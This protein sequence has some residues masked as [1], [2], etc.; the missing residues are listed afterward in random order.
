MNT[1]TPPSPLT[2]R[3]QRYRSLLMCAPEPVFMMDREGHFL[4]VND[5]TVRML[6]Y[7][8]E[9]LLKLNFRDI[10]VRDR[11]PATEAAFA[12]QMSSQQATP[13][14]KIAVLVKGGRRLELVV[15]GGP[16]VVN[17]EV[18]G[19][20][21]I[22]RELHESIDVW[23][24]W[25][26]T[27]PFFAWHADADGM[28]LQCNRRW[29]EY[30]G[31]TPAEAVGQGW[32]KAVHPDDIGKAWEDVAGALQ[33]GGS[34]QAEYRLRRKD[35]VYRWHQA[36][37]TSVQ[38]SNGKVIMWFGAGFD[39][40]DQKRAEAE[41]RQLSQEL[42]QR[43]RQRTAELAQTVVSLQE[44][45][46]RFRQLAESMREVFWMM[47]VA[48][49]KVLYL[50]PS[51]EEVWG[52]PRATVYESLRVWHD[53]VLLQD[54]YRLETMS[55]RGRQ[56]EWTEQ[57]RIRRPDGTVRWIREHG[58]PIRNAAGEVMRLAGLCEDVT[59]QHELEQALL[60]VSDREQRRIGQD[61]HDSVC[62]QLNGL[63]MLCK[64]IETRLTRAQHAE[65]ERVHEVRELL[66]QALVE[67]RNLAYSLCPGQPGSGDVAAALAQL[68]A[69]V[70]RLFRVQ[71]TV[72]VAEAI[73]ELDAQ[74]VAQLYRIAQ[75]AI[76]NA[77]RHGGAKQITVEMARQEQLI[78]L[79]VADNG[80]GLPANWQRNAGLGLRTMQYRTTLIGGRFN[81]RPAPNGTGTIAECSFRLPETGH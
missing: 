33:C 56:G 77:V 13:A 79:T 57:Y 39:I 80:R 69:T 18:V 27:M 6:G 17:G 72:K 30:T 14:E 26:D 73:G 22:A 11:L 47:D 21:G 46:Q 49:N 62:Q 61:L 37:S 23:R 71:C 3:E 16:L 54:R 66:S 51:F 75:E 15:S 1:T 59:Q 58:F 7:S 78:T 43:V 60:D 2:E 35:G 36:R 32:S 31:Q 52:I 53:S 4:E 64:V 55:Q 50:S 19:L 40:D 65:A 34:Y 25:L 48:A 42:E 9:E 10:C 67:T 8:R 12:S 41:L 68:G 63:T 81:L 74:M 29:Y 38:D 70:E 44:S 5:A 20:F 24:R 76:S 28:V 45:E